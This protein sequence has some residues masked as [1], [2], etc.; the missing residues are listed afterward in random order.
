MSPADRSWRR[1]FSFSDLCKT[2]FSHVRHEYRN[3]VNFLSFTCPAGCDAFTSQLW[4]TDIYTQNSYICAAALHS[5]RLPV[6]GGH[7]TVYKFPGV[8]E[9]IGSE[10]NGIESQS[11]KNSTI[12]FAF[13]DYC[14]W[15]AA[16]L[17]F[18]VNGT[19]MFNC[20]AGCN[21]SSKV[22]AGTTIYAS[23]SY[24]CIAA[25]HDGR[26]TDDGG[27][28]TVYQLPGQYYYFGTK[29]FGLTSRSY[30]FFQT[31]FALSDPCTRQANQIYFSQTTYANFPCPAGC[32]ATSSNVWGTI[33][34]KD[35]SFI[36]AAG[37]HDGRIPAS[38]GVVSVYKVT[39]LTSYSGSEQNNVVSKSYGSWNRSFSFED[40]C[41]KRINQVNFNGEN[42]TTYLC[43][44]DCQMKF[45]EVW[46]TVL[47]K[48]NSFICAAAIHYG[49]I[50]DVGGV[51]TLY[52]AGKIKHFPNSTQNAI[53]T[54]NLLT[55]WPR[56]AIAFKDLCAI[57]GYQLQF[58][59][60]NSVSFTCPPN[61]IR[62]SSQVWG[63]N[64]YSKRSHVCA[65]AT[66]DGK[67]SDSGGQFT[68][69]KIG[70]LPSYTGSEQNGITSLTS[71][72]RRRSIT[73]DDPCTKQADHLVSVY[74][75]CPPG[76]QN[77]TKRLWGTDIYTDDSYI[78]AAALHSNQ[79]GT[80]GGLVQVSKGG[81]QFSFT[82]S[83]REGITS[84]SYGSWL[85]SFTF[86]RN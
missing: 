48:D 10:R 17:T 62:T 39:G 69:Y 27:L 51:V 6:G 79:I 68:I 55:T 29:Q 63:T 80:K 22:L 7:I 20:P 65:A 49:A 12:A 28:V 70:G 85:R 8:L 71:R 53:T 59:G 31:S 84:K 35:D 36:C 30:G 58:N 75:P 32:N 57:Q 41:F 26:L 52:Q 50:A 16:A 24:I 19:T 15:P 83:T 44:P 23:L 43:P 9:F 47:Y 18:N 73:F 78:C 60:K 13:Q 67:I 25:I 81:A 72:H 86:V 3:G 42:S 14:K 74:F 82:G 45:Y 61:C 64:V 54:N 40:F 66:H 76:C 77:I 11:G 21:K 2:D 1:G 33:I 38:G 56:T 37:I 4:G 5:G 46:G 34:Y